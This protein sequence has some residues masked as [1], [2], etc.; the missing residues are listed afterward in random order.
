MATY[1][2]TSYLNQPK[3]L[4]AGDTVT[5]FSFNLGATASSAGDVIYLAKIPVG[6]V[7]ADLVE[8]HSTGATTQVVSFGYISSQSTS[9][10][11]FI[12]GGAQATVNRLN[13]APSATGGL[14]YQV[15]LSDD[16][17]QRFA[18]LVAKVESGT[19]TTS[20]IIQGNIRYT[21]GL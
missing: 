17:T 2:A 20:L 5:H 9:L 4:H 3:L 10:S 19:A 12:A 14:G 21:S 15:T 16:A 1:T 7:I 8:H 18:A 13:V 6:A 11:A